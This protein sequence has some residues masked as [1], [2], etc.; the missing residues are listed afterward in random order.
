MSEE[1]FYRRGREQV[2]AKGC[3]GN[4]AHLWKSSQVEFEET[5]DCVDVFHL[6]QIHI[7]GLV[8]LLSKFLDVVV[9][10]ADTIDALDGETASFHFEN[11]R[12]EDGWQTSSMCKTKC[13]KIHSELSLHVFRLGSAV[14][15][16]S[17]AASLVSSKSAVRTTH[18]LGRSKVD[19]KKRMCHLLYESPHEVPTKV[20]VMRHFEGVLNEAMSPG[21]RCLRNAS[22]WLSKIL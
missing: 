7:L 18:T 1:D 2:A 3:N 14:L 17:L 19:S 16:S 10:A 12:L 15:K 22:L 5:G 8:I 9:R 20:T 13:G 21:N 4:E 11:A 6:S